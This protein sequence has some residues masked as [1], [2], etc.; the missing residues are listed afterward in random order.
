MI[1]GNVFAFFELRDQTTI[2]ESLRHVLYAVLSVVS[3][4]GIGCLCFVTNSGGSEEDL[5]GQVSS[6]SAARVTRDAFVDAVKLLGTADMLMLL[7]I[8]L[9][10]GLE[11]TFYSGVYGTS[12]GFTKLFGDSAKSLVPLAGICIGIGEFTGGGLFGIYGQRSSGDGDVVGGEARDNF[13]SPR[14]RAILIGIA[15]QFTAFFIAFINLPSDSSLGATSSIPLI[16]HPSIALAMIG[17][18]LLG[19]GDACFNTKLMETLSTRWSDRSA[20]AY[21]IF[22]FAQSLSCGGAFFYSAVFDLRIQLGIMIAVGTVAAISFF[23]VD[24]RLRARESDP[25]GKA[26]SDDSRAILH[27]D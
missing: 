12:I 25:F 9:Y 11:L 3:L 8:F 7:P 18:F 27:A 22:K 10:S 1:W 16:G 20:P 19:F 4:I 23:F 13:C 6:R 26:A 5:S 24:Y 2:S 15:C 21:A 14:D 17:A